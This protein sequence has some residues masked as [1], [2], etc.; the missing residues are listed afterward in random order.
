M[1]KPLPTST[2]TFGDIIKGGYLYVD[3][4]QYLYQLVRESKGIYF[5]SRPRRFGKSLTIS[6]LEEIFHSN[7]ELFKGLWIEQSEYAWASHPVIRIDFS[8][9]KVSNIEELGDSIQR[10]LRQ[11]AA[12]HGV[13]LEDGPYEAQFASLIL[14]LAAEAQ[15]VILIDEYDKP[16]IDN[17][18]NRKE[19]IR[20]RDALRAFY[21][22]IKALDA[23]IRFVFMTGISKFSKVGVFSDLNH[24]HDLTMDPTF[25]AA[26]GITEDELI[27]D[28]ADYI[29]QFAQQEQLSATALLQKIRFWY[30]GFCFSDRCQL[31]YNPFSTLNM[32]KQQRFSNFWF[33]SGT[34][35]FL[36]K[37]IKAQGYNVEQLSHLNLAEIE[38][39]T[40]EIEQLAIVPLL[41]Q[42]GYLTIIES[43][44]E[45]EDRIYRLDH[46][47]YEVKHAF[48]SY[49]LSEFSEMERSFS[50]SYLRQLV[51][52]LRDTDL[53]QFF[54]TLDVFFANI[55]YELYLKNER[56]YQTIF[57]LIFL[58]IGVQIDA[59]V[60]TN[61]G[62]IDAVVELSEHIFIF[63]FKLDRSAKEALQQIKEREYYQKY[64]LKGKS[65]TLV[66]ANFDSTLRKVSEWVTA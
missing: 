14:Q 44:V 32:F 53:A 48:A 45:G 21:R 4:T 27:T 66:G 49:L 50:G 18:E 35:M 11:I 23:H 9:Y 41:F 47:N 24:L 34:P 54:E 25:S 5:L 46:P 6:T 12:Q 52:A 43:F 58:M 17:I 8:L 37:H 30:N 19:A 31:V 26:L 55:D 51:R 60:N 22:V 16:I 38:F 20:I 39:S 59:E 56:Y 2:H 15:V 28:F 10:Y 40:Y 3:K 61:R 7:R 65:I 13:S 64:R 33:E 57:Y 42:T 29:T 1:L 62:R 36:I 63:E